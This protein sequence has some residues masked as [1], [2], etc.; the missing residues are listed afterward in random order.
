LTAEDVK[1]CADYAMDAK[2]GSEGLSYLRE[3]KA[4]TMPD[5]YTIEFTL[6]EPNAVFLSYLALRAFPVVPKGSVPSGADKIDTFPPGTGPF[7]FKEWRK[8]SHVSFAPTRTIGK[9]MFPI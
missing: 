5:R 9:R 4:I 2:N 7:V 1:W 3:V 6:K 8:L